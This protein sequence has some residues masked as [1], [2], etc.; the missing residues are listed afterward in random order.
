MSWEVY[1]IEKKKKKC[2]SCSVLPC[3][4]VTC[5]HYDVINSHVLFESCRVTLGKSVKLI[6]SGIFACVLFTTQTILNTSQRRGK[7]I[8]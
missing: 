3:V 6:N 2:I 4:Q 8:G 7:N 5:A 1:L